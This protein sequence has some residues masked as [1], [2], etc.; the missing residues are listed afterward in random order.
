MRAEVLLKDN[1]SGYICGCGRWIEQS[2]RTVLRRRKTKTGLREAE[3]SIQ[4]QALLRLQ[5]SLASYDFGGSARSGGRARAIK[6]VGSHCCTAIGSAAAIDWSAGVSRPVR[7]KAATRLSVSLRRR[8]RFRRSSLIIREM[9]RRCA[10]SWGEWEA[11]RR[12]SQVSSMH[13]RRR[14][15]SELFC[16]WGWGT[17]ERACRS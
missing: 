6:V 11:Y 2:R 9:R 14:S 12:E 13:A 17:R 4:L 8:C 5:H 7:S 3:D 16:A 10:L 15:V 1:C